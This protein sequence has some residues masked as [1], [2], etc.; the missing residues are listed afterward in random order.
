MLRIGLV[1]LGN[2]GQTYAQL[3]QSGRIKRARLAAVVS[4][5]TDNALA[6]PHFSDYQALLAANLVDA[7]LVAT[8]T[9]L[10]P[11][12]G[13][14]VVDAGLHLLMEKPL[15][16]SVG[17][18]AAVIRHT[19]AQIK[20]AVMLN[21]RFHPHYQ[22]LYNQ[23]HSGA[24]GEIMR[25][26]WTLTAWS[27][28]DIYYQVSDWRGT[29]PGEGGGLLINQCIHNLDVLQWLTG[30][31]SKVSAIAGF[32]KYHAIDV[33]DEFT[34]TLTYANGAMGVIVASS[35]E[36]PGVNQLDIV[37]ERGMLRFDGNSLTRWQSDTSVRD[38]CRN[39]HEM[40]GM[41]SYE[42]DVVDVSGAMP[43]RGQ[44]A[45]VLQNFIDAVLD[46]SPL[47]TP[48]TAGLNSLHL[49]NGILLSAWSSEPVNLPLDAQRYEAALQQRIA[50]SSL[51]DPV[52]RDVQIDMAKSFR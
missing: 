23:I 16:M 31:P 22:A 12:M 1:G 25:V 18:A 17:Q 29:W 28:P 33:E 21:Q 6:V 41:P 24:I 35:G 10:H 36:A 38:H 9:M 51:R 34:A 3:L 7:V 2:I 30:L 11:Q 37:G 45:V 47:A 49:A 32:G 48:A 15:A 4:R 5:T 42:V 40:F 26:A 46:D 52:A 8:P 43:A 50:Q 39:T 14:Q 13:Q 44:H 20:F 27:W 19:P